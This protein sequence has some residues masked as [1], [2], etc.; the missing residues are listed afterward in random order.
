MK[1]FMLFLLLSLASNSYAQ[2]LKNE[3]SCKAE[4]KKIEKALG[5]EGV[6][7]K[8]TGENF[9]KAIEALQKSF[10]YPTG[11]D[12][13]QYTQAIEK[14]SKKLPK[15]MENLVR[16]S[17]YGFKTDLIKSLYGL[18][19]SEKN[20][21][22]RGEIAEGLQKYFRIQKSNTFLE[23]SIQTKQFE[24]V[25]KIFKPEDKALLKEIQIYRSEIKTA[26]KKFEDQ[27][28]LLKFDDPKAFTEEHYK[29]LLEEDQE[30]RRLQEVFIETVKGTKL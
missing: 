3:E 5:S 29:A 2:D 21:D 4:K 30:S 17:C 26:V 22:I 9:K 11:S 14:K 7:A 8:I 6:K 28:G 16:R 18:A 10:T 13:K 15:L 23:M 25:V 12:L 27:Y 19:K 20:E 24:E 1:Y